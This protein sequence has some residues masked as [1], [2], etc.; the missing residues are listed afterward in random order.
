M[1]QFEKE[2]FSRAFR[3]AQTE[4]V[5][6]VMPQNVRK[7]QVEQLGFA[8]L[9]QTLGEQTFDF[10]VGGLVRQ[11]GNLGLGCLLGAVLAPLRYPIHGLQ[12]LAAY[13]GHMAPSGRIVVAA[14]FQSADEMR[15][16]HRIAYR[17]RQLQNKRVAFGK[18][19]KAEWQSEPMWQPLR[20]MIERLLVTFDWAE[21]F[22]GV[23][24][25]LKPMFQDARVR[26]AI[27]H[28]IDYK[29]INDTVLKHY[30]TMWVGPLAPNLQPQIP[31]P[32]WKLDPAKA[33]KL[34]ADAG[35]PNGFNVTL[36]VLSDTPLIDIDVRYVTSAPA[37]AV[38]VIGSGS[39]RVDLSMSR[40]ASHDEAPRVMRKT[41][42]WSSGDQVMSR[43]MSPSTPT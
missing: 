24:L 34:L 33:K 43:R 9:D 7:P 2:L 41:I 36:R 1:A 42:H 6:N 35:F 32:E 16:V 26:E 17:M 39:V 28:L 21:A 38:T 8:F 31:T 14:A 18:D 27:R 20:E 4:T 25:V 37:V 10:A 30:G 3:R 40:S 12:M 5:F 19:S 11:R 23:N 15:R 29:G 13:V 22:T